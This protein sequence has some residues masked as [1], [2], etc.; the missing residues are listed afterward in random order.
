MP[1]RA[2]AGFLLFNKN[3]EAAESLVSQDEF[4]DWEIASLDPG[5]VVCKGE[6][7]RIPASA[8]RS[9]I[10]GINLYPLLQLHSELKEPQTEVYAGLRKLHV[11]AI[12]L[13]S[14]CDFI[15]WDKHSEYRQTIPGLKEFYFPDAGHYIDISQPKKLAAV[16]RAFLLDQ[17]PPS[18]SYEGDTDPRPPI[19]VDGR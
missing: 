4:G 13:Y 8:S 5:Q 6:M 11:P 19:P 9:L 18:P 16:I 12:A 2:I 1:V 10:A 3:P 14:Q 7:N 17:P 15:P